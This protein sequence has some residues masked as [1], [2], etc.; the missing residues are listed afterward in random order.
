MFLLL[1]KSLLYM[2]LIWLYFDIIK[3]MI[4]PSNANIVV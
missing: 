4:G 1:S 3:V 2:F